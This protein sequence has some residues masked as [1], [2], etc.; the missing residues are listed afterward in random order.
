[1]VS[2]GGFDAGLASWSSSALGSGTVGFD[3]GADADASPSSGSAKIVSDTTFTK[4]QQCITGIVPGRQYYFSGR[5][6]FSTAETAGADASVVLSFYATPD[7]KKPLPVFQRRQ[8][9]T[10]GGRGVWLTAKYGDITSGLTAPD[11]AQSATIVADAFAIGD[12]NVISVDVDRLFVAPV[13]EPLCNGLVPTIGGTDGP[14]VIVGTPGP[15]VIVGLEGDDVIYGKGGDDVICGGPGNDT[16]IGGGGN[17]KLFGGPG[18]D[19]LRGGSGDDELFGGAGDDHLSGGTG[20]DH[21]DGGPGNDTCSGGPGS[22]DSATGSCE[23]VTT[24]P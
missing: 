23:V 7:C 18:D 6:R 19:I 3:P 16:L 21:L 15:D 20:N 8:L 5:I 24:V 10:G 22:N 2:N 9:T 12:G 17:D 14:D 11:G 13:G 4:L 1:M